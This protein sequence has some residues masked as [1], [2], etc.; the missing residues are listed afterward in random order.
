M[1]K[2]FGSLMGSIALGFFLGFSGVLGKIYGIPFDIRHITIAAGNT[3]IAVY[4]LGL[5]H[6]PSWGIR[7]WPYEFP[8]ELFPGLCH[9]SEIKGN[10]SVAIPPFNQN[11]RLVFSQASERFYPATG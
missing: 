8:G 2:H 9:G 7:D 10:S 3:A 5:D 11:H 1:E 4:G 6:I